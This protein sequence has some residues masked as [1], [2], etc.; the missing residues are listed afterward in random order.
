MVLDIYFFVLNASSFIIKDY[1]KIN[2]VYIYLLIKLAILIHFN[3]TNYNTVTNN[4]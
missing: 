3:K 2:K 4:L 1:L